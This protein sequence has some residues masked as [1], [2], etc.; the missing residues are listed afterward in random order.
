MINEKLSCLKLSKIP[1]NFL[2]QLIDY[3][4]ND[5]SFRES[6]HVLHIFKL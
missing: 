5:F 3:H 2:V 4:K 6:V 1:I